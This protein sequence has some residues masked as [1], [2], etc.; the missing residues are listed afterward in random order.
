MQ[1]NLILNKKKITTKAGYVAIIGKPNAGKSTF[2]NSV[3]GTKL[4][5]IT[6]KPQTT[7]KRV[8]GI[9]TEANIQI[10]FIDTPGVLNPK[11]AMQSTMME[12]VHNSIEI[13]DCII[14]IYDVIKF[15]KI[16]PISDVLYNFFKKEKK[17][18]ILL[19]N[20]IDLLKDSKE[21]LPL[22]KCFYD[23]NLFS[24]I[25]PI[26]ALKEKKLNKKILDVI[27]KYLSESEFFYDA[28]LLSNQPERFFVSE[29]IRENIFLSYGEEIPYS[30]EVS[31]IEFKEREYGKWFISAEIIVERE[32]QK[33]IIIGRKAEKLKKVSEISR[34][35]IEEHLEHSVYLEVFVK[36][37][38]N[39]RD[40]HFMLRSLGY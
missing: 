33:K 27:T 26:S 13:A 28:D 5:I 7:R 25:V 36:V 22:I 3:I 9:C 20:K 30:T 14:L 40:N 37:R 4:S 24:D 11:Y 16:K 10:I 38:D 23:M 19:L 8:L 39:W 2:L 18:V 29:I 32:T 15:N 6:P 31:I 17:P 12:Y 21:V 1:N 35:Q 34:K